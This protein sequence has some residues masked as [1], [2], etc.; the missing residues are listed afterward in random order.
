M[1]PSTTPTQANQIRGRYAPSP[2]G[3]LHMGNLRTAL[4]AWLCARLE[5]GCFIL[6]IED[7][8]LPRVRFGATERMLYDLRWLGLD[9]DEGPD[10]GGPHAPYT[11]SERLHHY[12][13]YLKQ[14]EQADLIYPC[15]CSRAEIVHA[16]SAPQQGAED[17]PRYPGTC[18]N[19]STRQRQERARVRQP[20]LRFRVPEKSV[21]RFNDLV[22]G[23]VEQDVGQVVGDFIVRRSDGIFAYQF[24]VVVDDALM[25]INQ[26]VRGVDLLSSAARQ[27]L[28][29]RVLGFPEPT[30]AH[31]PLIM[32][33]DT[34]KRLS[35]RDG[36]MG[37]APLRAAGQT[38]Q[39]IIGQ[40]ATS[41]GLIPD[42]TLLTPSQL[43]SAC[44]R[45]LYDIMAKITL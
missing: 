30:F 25:R 21:I 23:P 45:S 24:A 9:W 3:D 42:G 35:K 22:A 10:C 13:T 44:H 40:L 5:Q 26:V 11:Q 4:L 15:Y 33:N 32:D 6:R 31:M 38:P 7:L 18:R 37:L 19:L 17:G 29:F 20:S 36:S 43:L 14:L 28:L 16:A 41:C 27:L 34:G 39:H 2:T 12:H 1:I 8:D